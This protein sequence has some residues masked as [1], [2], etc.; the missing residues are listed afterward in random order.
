MFRCPKLCTTTTTMTWTKIRGEFSH[1]LIYMPTQLLR[2]YVCPKYCTNVWVYEKLK[3][4]F[5]L[6]TWISPITEVFP[7]LNVLVFVCFSLFSIYVFVNFIGVF[8]CPGAFACTCTQFVRS[9]YN[10]PY[11]PVTCV[12]PSLIFRRFFP[13]IESYDEPRVCVSN[14]SDDVQLFIFVGYIF[15]PCLAKKV[16]LRNFLLF[17]M[18]YWSRRNFIKYFK[19]VCWNSWSGTWC[20]LVIFFTNRCVLWI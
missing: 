17:L 16:T 14:T 1:N 19:I 13:R 6:L 4:K 15:H 9:F 7:V 12:F 8:V 2:L 3:V 5:P 11:S 10:P 20:A 18:F